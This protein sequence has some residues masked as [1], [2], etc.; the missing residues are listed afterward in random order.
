MKKL[1]KVQVVLLL[2]LGV[3][4]VSSCSN[5]GKSFYDSMIDP[6]SKTSAFASVEQSLSLSE[7]AQE[8]PE[9]S[10]KVEPVLMSSLENLI[11]ESDYIIIATVTDILPAFT[12][13]KDHKIT[14]V[15]SG[16]GC[17][18]YTPY[19]LTV[20]QVISGDVAI[21]ETIRID[22]MGGEASGV[23]FTC[24]PI[25]YPEINTTYL[26]FLQDFDWVIEHDLEYNRIVF[27]GSYDGFYKADENKLFPNAHSTLIPVGTSLQDV[28]EI[29]KDRQQFS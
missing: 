11:D 23:K 3:I 19:L 12:V 26:M 16:L 20:D 21:N 1:G 24:S 28:I 29:I 2:I 6:A 4:F 27:T 5:F 9:V 8:N 7:F 17:T 15:F 18:N 22:L 25:A 13:S 10:A 14:D